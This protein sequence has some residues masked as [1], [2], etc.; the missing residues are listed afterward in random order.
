MYVCIYVCVYIDIYIPYIHNYIF[1]KK[2]YDRWRLTYFA[3][4]AAQPPSIFKNSPK[5][6]KSIY[7]HGDCDMVQVKG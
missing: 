2:I 4:K 5:I 7:R 3:L 6:E 1:G